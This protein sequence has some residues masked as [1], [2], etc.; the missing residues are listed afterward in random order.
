MKNDW[1]QVR[2]EPSVTAVLFESCMDFGKENVV[3]IDGFQKF[4]GTYMTENT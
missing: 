1:S 2:E 3:I 4:M